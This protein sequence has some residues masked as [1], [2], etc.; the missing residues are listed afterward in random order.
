MGVYRYRLENLHAIADFKAQY[1]ILDNDRVRL[2]NPEDLLDGLAFNN[3]WMSFWLVAVIEDG[4]RFSLHPLLKDCLR[5]WNLC[6]YQLMPNCFKIIMRVVELNRILGIDLSVSDIEDVYDMC[7]SG[8]ENVYYLRMRAR[9]SSFV[10]AL[11][12][13][14]RYARDDRVFVSGEWEFGKLEASRLVR[15]PRRL[16]T[17]PSKD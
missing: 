5:E 17:P 15:I 16:R 9:R 10:T 8:D 6:P 14:N 13:S 12:D 1:R 4:V 2:D 7:K 3:G 11:E